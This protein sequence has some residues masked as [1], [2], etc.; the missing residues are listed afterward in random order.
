MTRQGILKKMTV[1][2]VAA[3]LFVGFPRFYRRL[4]T[5]AVASVFPDL[6]I[7]IG[8][9][10]PSSV[11][12]PASPVL[13]DIRVSFRPTG[14]IVAQ[15]DRIVV[16]DGSAEIAGGEI[17]VDR[18]RF[19]TPDPE[20]LNAALL[21]AL[22][23]EKLPG[24]RAWK[25][26]LRAIEVIDSTGYLKDR[27]VEITNGRVRLAPGSG[28]DLRMRIGGDLAGTA[29]GRIADQDGTLDLDVRVSGRYSM[30]NATLPLDI[31]VRS[32]HLRLIR[33]DAALGVPLGEFRLVDLRTV[34]SP[35]EILTKKPLE[36]IKNFGKILMP[37]D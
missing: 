10:V 32:S 2:L 9:A 1:V 17:Y 23:G 24:G 19:G 22:G 16:G 30:K 11:F 26:L 35:V 7:R 14:R 8:S 13:H 33:I 34:E 27:D 18:E 25:V 28:I 31:K 6:E 36:G 5:S 20:R 37:A 21:A 4:V 15:F 12:A 3:L 29:D